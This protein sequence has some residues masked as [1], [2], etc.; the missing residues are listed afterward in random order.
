MNHLLGLL[1]PLIFE[2]ERN[3][4]KKIATS[5]W[6]IDYSC[7]NLL[8]PLHFSLFSLRAYT[9]LHWI[10]NY[11]TGAPDFLRPTRTLHLDIIPLPR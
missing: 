1:R 11:E 2:E 5:S 9:K 4:K 3:N 6:P 7:C 8:I 10:S